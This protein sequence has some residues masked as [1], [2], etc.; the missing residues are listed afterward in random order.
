MFDVFDVF[1]V[2][3]Y[4]GHR[5]NAVDVAGPYKSPPS[6][7]FSLARSRASRVYATSRARRLAPEEINLM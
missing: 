7:L 4:F 5:A 3:D 6:A 1:D 2:F